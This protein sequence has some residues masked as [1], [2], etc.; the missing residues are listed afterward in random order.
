[1]NQRHFSFNFTVI[2]F[3]FFL[4]LFQEGV[5]FT[6]RSW[7]QL[8]QFLQ[9]CP[10]DTRITQYFTESPSKISQALFRLAS[11][12]LKKPNTVPSLCSHVWATLA[13]LLKSTYAAMSKAVLSTRSVDWSGLGKEKHRD[14][15]QSGSLP[16]SASVL[17]LTTAASAWL[18]SY[19]TAAQRWEGG[20][21]HKDNLKYFSHQ[22]Q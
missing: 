16:W 20:A 12:L 4:V 13:R 10:P 1:M 5:A 14:A 2:F 9:Q 15:F 19:W 18:R 6:F 21:K 11:E 7:K 3:L 22:R 8:L 17:S